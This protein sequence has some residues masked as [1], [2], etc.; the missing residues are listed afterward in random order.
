MSLGGI[1]NMC[2][3]SGLQIM[4]A[5]AADRSCD[6][7]SVRAGLALDEMVFKM[8]ATLSN[9]ICAP[10]VTTVHFIGY[11]STERSQK[12]FSGELQLDA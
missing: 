8:A 1:D 2:L 5:R 9:L 7:K 11:K 6:V 12:L 4:V 3:N 10:N